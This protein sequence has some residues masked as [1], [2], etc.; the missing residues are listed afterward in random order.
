MGWEIPHYTQ[1][2]GFLRLFLT[3]T[4]ARCTLLV[5]QDQ[6]SCQ[7]SRRCPGRTPNDRR[8]AKLCADRDEFEFEASVELRSSAVEQVRPRTRDRLFRCRSDHPALTKLG[9][10][11]MRTGAVRTARGQSGIGRTERRSRTVHP[12]FDR[13]DRSPSLFAP[14]HRSLRS[15]TLAWELSPRHR[16]NSGTSSATMASGAIDLDDVTLP[17]VLGRGA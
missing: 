11:H 3:G 6:Q 1:S 2:L 7:Q 14:R 15:S 8:G 9:R 17:E 13:N 4:V 5:Y 16:R 10:G 12:P